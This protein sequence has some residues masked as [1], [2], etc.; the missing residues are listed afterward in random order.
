MKPKAPMRH[1]VLEF[2]EGGRGTQPP[3]P[4]IEGLLDEMRTSLQGVDRPDFLQRLAKKFREEGMA[5]VF[6]PTGKAAGRRLARVRA[7]FDSNEILPS[8]RDAVKLTRSTFEKFN[9][10][11]KEVILDW[12]GDERNFLLAKKPLTSNPSSLAQI[13]NWINTIESKLALFPLPLGKR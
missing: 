8:Q 4:D 9:E 7:I 12:F 3:R 13:D 6:K 5:D 2:P 10:I 11:D 1:D